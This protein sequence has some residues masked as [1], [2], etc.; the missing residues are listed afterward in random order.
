MKRLLFIT[1]KY[2][3]PLTSGDRLRAYNFLQIL[4]KEFDIDLLVFEKPPENKNTEVLPVHNIFYVPISP[5]ERKIDFVAGMIRGLPIQVAYY[6]HRKVAN[7]IKEIIGSY[8]ILFCHLART[9]E[10]AKDISLPKILDYSDSFSL[11]YAPHQR[12]KGFWGWF[13][14]FEYPRMKAYEKKISQRFDTCLIASERDANWLKDHC[15]VAREKIHVVPNGVPENSLQ[16]NRVEPAKPTLIFSGNMNYYPNVDAITFFVKNIFPDIAAHVPD[17]CLYIVG[18]YPS[19]EVRALAS[20]RIMVTGYVD[21]MS[22]Y[23]KRATLAIAPLRIAS[24]IQNKI[25]EALAVG[26][27]VVAS[28]AAADGLGLTPAMRS[29]VIVSSCENMAGAI[30]SLLRDP[31]KRVQLEQDAHEFISKQYTQA[32]ISKKLFDL[33]VE[34][35][36]IS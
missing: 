2:P 15:G 30:I 11:L 35:K 5:L 29:G 26:V 9:A 17:V 7:K 4:S 16:Q 1:T 8:D 33:V 22:E 3:L 13:S 32:S 34:M 14:F 24:G 20:E 28:R 12:Q 10:Y 19:K 36:I 21:N 18:A 31:D 27:P 6:T 23:I 25:L